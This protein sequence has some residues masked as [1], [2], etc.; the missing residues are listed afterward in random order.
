MKT[1]ALTLT[2]AALFAASTAFAGDKCCAMQ[3]K[4]DK[5]GCSMALTKLELTAEQK[6]KMESLIAD[7]EKNGCTEGSMAK[8]ET[9]AKTI[10]SE[11][12]FAAFQ[13][14][15]CLGKKSEKKAS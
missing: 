2:A 13:S 7:C 11:E 3:A 12:Q 10:L 6:T 9:E 5:T 8:L 15:S 1:I 14:A 4:N